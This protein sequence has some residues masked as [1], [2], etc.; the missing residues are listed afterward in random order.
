MANSYIEVPGTSERLQSYLNTVEGT[1]VHSEAVTL[2]DSAGAELKGQKTAAASIPVVLASDQ[3]VTLSP[4]SLAALEDINVTVTV[5]PEIEIKNDSGNPV[6][7]SSTDLDIRDLV[8]ATDKVDA[9]GTVLG[10]G[11]NNIGN[12]DVVTLPITQPLTDT[13]LRA[14]AV[15]VSATNLDI[16]DL[17]SAS[18]SVSVL[19]ATHD[20]L[21][22]NANL[23]I[24]NADASITNQ[25]P[26]ADTYAMRF[27]AGAVRH[28]GA[29]ITSGIASTQSFRLGNPTSSGKTIVILAVLL[30]STTNATFTLNKNGTLDSP[31]TITPWNPNFSGSDT[32]V[33]VAQT[34]VAAFTGG[35]AIATSLRSGADI[36]LT[37]PF[38]ILLAENTSIGVT[39][40]YA[41]GATTHV[42][43][44][45]AEF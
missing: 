29:S 42:N 6:P 4:A 25:V 15:P 28:A 20:N 43:V 10:A 18:D 33:A 31:T 16:R 17:A 13:E 7:V 2:T 14:T 36:T 32:T 44:I 27:G 5:A 21:N 34:Q 23:Q 26:I 40:T 9:T 11:D 19:Q 3:E 22:L 37:L 35:T 30:T 24:A 1:S 12:V 41:T 45:Y 8:F 39:V 38:T